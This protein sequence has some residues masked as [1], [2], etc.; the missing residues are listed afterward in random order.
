MLLIL[1][2]SIS[3]AQP[4]EAAKSI[5]KAYPDTFQNMLNLAQ[6]TFEMPKGAIPIPIVKN[7][8]MHY[9]YALTFKDQPFEVRYSVA[10]LGYSVAEAYVGGK[11]V[12]PRKNPAEGLNPQAIS[13]A[14]A[15]NV[16]GG[17]PTQGMGSRPFPPEAVKREFGADWGATTIIP[18][19]NNS[20]GTDYKYC[21]MISLF[22]K[23]VANAYIMYLS[24]TKENA[25][26]L[27]KELI[28]FKGAFYALKF[29]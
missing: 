26:K 3:K 13:A 20:F 1:I 19:G 12:T 2:N 17:K 28:A 22:K 27:L 29:K 15:I 16:A 11:N 5:E 25:E 8:Q 7:I 23:D 10:P 18:L 4:N 6:M 21:I 24:D 9:E 14:V